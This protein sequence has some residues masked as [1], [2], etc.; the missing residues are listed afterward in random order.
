MTHPFFL[1]SF[2]LV[3]F[4]ATA[5]SA[6]PAKNVIETATATA[7]V[8]ATVESSTPLNH[9]PVKL[10]GL[11]GTR[12]S[13]HKMHVPVMEELAKVHRFHKGRVKK[14]RRFGSQYWVSLKLLLV[15]CHIALLVCAYL[16]V[17]H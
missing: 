2:F 5:A 11:M 6:S 13:H 3:C 7:T 8:V 4:F 12:P 9:L 10:P 14:A 15:I 1:T 16:H 17:T